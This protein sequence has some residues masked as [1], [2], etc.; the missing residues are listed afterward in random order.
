MIAFELFRCNSSTVV[1]PDINKLNLSS[2]LA[3]QNNSNSDPCKFLGSYSLSSRSESP[4]LLRAAA[5]AVE[6]D[7][8]LGASFLS[9]LQINRLQLLENRR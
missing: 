5:G 2:T 1:I 6:D 4:T 8:N 9:A 7:A 3:G